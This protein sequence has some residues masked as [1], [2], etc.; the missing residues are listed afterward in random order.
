MIQD[1]RGY[2]CALCIRT[3]PVQ[4]SAALRLLVACLTS[5]LKNFGR[6]LKSI[7]NARRKGTLIGNLIPVSLRV[8]ALAG[9]LIEQLGQQR[10][11]IGLVED[12]QGIIPL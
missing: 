6:E 10:L 9:G 4:K 5:A 2:Q 12:E 7:K 3:G 8:V 1:K 11:R